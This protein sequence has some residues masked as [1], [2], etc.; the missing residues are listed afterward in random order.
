MSAK[1]IGYLFI[2]SAAALWGTFSVISKV[3]FNQAYFDPVELTQI[4]AFASG[5]TL[6]LILFVVNRKLLRIDIRSFGVYFLL[7]FTI[8]HVQLAL[9][10][11]INITDVSIASFLQYLAPALIFS[12]LVFFHHEPVHLKDIFI[13]GLAVAGVVFLIVSSCQSKLNMLGIIAGLWTAV[14]LSIYTVYSKFVAQRYNIWAALAYGMLSMSLLLL[15]VFPPSIKLFDGFPYNI[16][17]FLLYLSFFTIIIPYGLFLLGMRF[18]KPHQASITA[19]LEPVVAIILSALLSLELLTPTKIIGC[20][21]IISSVI[22]LAYQNINHQE[23]T[24][25]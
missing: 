2:A 7:G 20:L 15:M 11:A 18:L 25:N 21:L 12:Y 19:T 8:I 4:R 5:I 10:F 22:L 24:E 1:F 17:L 14:A 23:K 16:T 13:L 9:F 6:F 3:L